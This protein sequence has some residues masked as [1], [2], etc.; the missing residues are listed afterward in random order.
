MQTSQMGQHQALGHTDRR[1]DSSQAPVHC[2]LHLVL[3][4]EPVLSASRDCELCC[5]AAGVAC[6]GATFGADVGIASLGSACS[7]R[8]ARRIVR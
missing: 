1:S 5:V 8:Q 6:C 2:P 3:F 7:R 4:R